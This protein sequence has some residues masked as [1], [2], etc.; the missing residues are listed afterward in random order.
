MLAEFKM[1]DSPRTDV[2]R[3][4]RP[5]LSSPD[6]IAHRRAEGVGR[7]TSTRPPCPR[8]WST[9]PTMPASPPPAAR[10]GFRPGSFLGDCPAERQLA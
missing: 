2:H 10:E 5:I 9:R 7:S 6:I 8:C 4:A 3:P 1:L